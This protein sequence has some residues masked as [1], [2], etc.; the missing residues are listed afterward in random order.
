MVGTSRVSS[1]SII[2]V[3]LP[4]SFVAT[5]TLASLFSITLSWHLILMTRGML[6]KQAEN[7]SA[8]MPFKW[9]NNCLL[10]TGSMLH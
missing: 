3:V 7:M 4:R 10:V 8:I 6:V 2:F 5:F 9:S 1:L